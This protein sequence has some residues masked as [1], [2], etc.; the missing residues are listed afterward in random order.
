[1]SH[2]IAILKKYKEYFEAAAALIL[3]ILFLYVT[4]IGCPIKF[5]TGI[6]CAGCG[7]SRAYFSLLRLDFKSAW[8]YHP[9]F[10]V[11]PLFVLTLIFKEKIGDIAFKIILFTIV[12]SFVIIYVY[13]MVFMTGDIVVFRPENGLIYRVYLFLRRTSD[14]LF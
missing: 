12:I 5:L 6:S 7:M 14:V 13:R 10:F 3:V 8:E 9:L 4:K 11:P 1:M 2:I